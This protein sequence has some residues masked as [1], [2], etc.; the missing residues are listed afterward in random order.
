MSS[1]KF[2]HLFT[3][4]NFAQILF[5]QL[6]F[7]FGLTQAVWA[8]CSGRRPV[9]TCG[10]CQHNPPCVT[11]P[12]H[13]CHTKSEIMLHSSFRKGEKLL[14]IFSTQ[15]AA[16]KKDPSHFCVFWILHLSGERQL[17]SIDSV[18]SDTVPKQGENETEHYSQTVKNI[19]LLHYLNIDNFY[20]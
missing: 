18:V 13:I 17:Y 1:S 6:F 8:R 14:H 19:W 9:T 20:Q 3:G 7:T 15:C 5:R 12:S 2:S 11:C 16:G 10:V 4:A